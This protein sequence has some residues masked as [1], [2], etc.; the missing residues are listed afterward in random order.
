MPHIATWEQHAGLIRRGFGAPTRHNGRRVAF[1]LAMLV[2]I[3]LVVDVAVVG[4]ENQPR[5]LFVTALALTEVLLV[6]LM[7][8]YP[9]GRLR[10]SVD[11]LLVTAAAAAVLPALVGTL[12][13]V[14]MFAVTI[15]VVVRLRE[16]IRDATPVTRPVLTGVFA[17]AIAHA[18]T[19]GAA[20]VLGDGVVAS[21]VAAWLVAAALAAMVLGFVAEG[22]RSRLF[23]VR[24]LQRLAEC[25][26]TLPDAATLRRAVAA[27][28]D[29]LAVEIV[30][31]SGAPDGGW[32]DGAGQRTVS[33]IRA[34]DAASSGV[35]D[36]DTLIA[37]IVHDEDLRE[38]NPQSGGRRRDS[39]DLSSTTSA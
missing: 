3:V 9:T 12:G 30:F 15:A 11:R 32:M 6:Y 34:P 14:G 10:N 20:L 27:A 24:A 35:R 7:L 36:G 31:P 18:A 8:S 22:V 28:F 38:Q 13:L 16:R 1:A 2:A 25:A 5:P 26:R 21:E 33:P 17:V 19:I 23:A 39:R 37:A 29:D 4:A